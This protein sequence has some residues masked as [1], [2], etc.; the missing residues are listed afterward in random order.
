MLDQPK[1]INAPGIDTPLR[2]Q[3]LA[4]YVLAIP[5]PNH[6][7]RRELA[8][9]QRGYFEATQLRSE[10]AKLRVEVDELRLTKGTVI[11][12]TPPQ[13]VMSAKVDR[14]AVAEA[15]SKVGLT[16]NKV[17]CPLC[18]KEVSPLKG[19]WAAHFKHKHPGEPIPNPL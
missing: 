18:A 10:N 1:V 6:L 9:L 3:T 19:P 7:V 2:E 15:G 12:L 13:V 4:E 16:P 5:D 11:Q 14:Q 8:E 17:M